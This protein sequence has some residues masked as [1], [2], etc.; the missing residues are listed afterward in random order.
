VFSLLKAGAGQIDDPT[1]FGFE[2][3]LHCRH[4]D[5][6]ELREEIDAE[7]YALSCA[8]FDRYHRLPDLFAREGVL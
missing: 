7:Y 6:A 4:Q 1:R 2:V 3:L 5:L 8:H